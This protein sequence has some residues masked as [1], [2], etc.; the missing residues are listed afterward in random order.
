[1]E[2]QHQSWPEAGG[3]A[4]PTRAARSPRR[5]PL[6]AAAAVLVVSLGLLGVIVSSRGRGT[7]DPQDLTTQTSAGPAPAAALAAAPAASRAGG[8]ARIR[9]SMRTMES[10]QAVTV[11][12]E[13]VVA[14]DSGAYDLRY[15]AEGPDLFPMALPPG[16]DNRAFSDGTT[17]WVSLPPDGGLVG[18]S[19]GSKAKL[20]GKRYLALP[21]NEEDEEG[22]D[23]SLLG[24]SSVTG[25][26]LGFS[27]GDKP[28][29]V[30]GYLASVGRV[31]REGGEQLGGDDVDRYAVE[32]DLDALQR[33]LP[34][35]ERSFDAYD[36][37]PDVAHTFPAKVWLDRSGRLR[38]LTYRLDLAG[39]L[40]EVALR[41]DYTAQ[42]CPEPDPQLARRLQSGDESAFAAL[43]KLEERCTTR[44]AR[45]EELAIEGSVELSDYGTPL[46]VT[47]PPATEVLTAAQLDAFLE[48]G[49]IPSPTASARSSATT[50]RSKP[51]APKPTTTASTTTVRRPTTTRG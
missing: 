44:P 6:L 41:E 14:F 25:Q 31:V 51:V 8:T 46:T 23:W 7:D 22:Q 32:L 43:E 21:G 35:E 50:V 10:G 48:L 4:D 30:L 29:D 34:S 15:V 47:P 18:A 16:F 39:L 26:G 11:G 36:F 17:V 5:A 3:E 49:P 9:T 24:A 42:D 20:R 13:G 2:E 27:I 45:P 28:G 1:V 40:T 38:K 33:A 12:V 37:K 19:P